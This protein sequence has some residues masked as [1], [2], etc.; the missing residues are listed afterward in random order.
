MPVRMGAAIAL[1]FVAFGAGGMPQAGTAGQG[2]GRL[3][4]ITQISYGCPGPQSEGEPCE[5]WSSFAH[6]R[7]RLTPLSSGD[8]RIVT[9]DRR[10]RFTLVLTVGRYRVTPLRQAHTTGGTP[11]TVTIRAVATTW[12]RV[13]FQGFPRML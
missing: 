2:P 3:S 7:F 9:S 8:A 13:R 1:S 11:L 4:G 10:G 12:T 5:R 6:A